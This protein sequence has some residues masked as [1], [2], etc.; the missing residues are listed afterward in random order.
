M[1]LGADISYAA[2]AVT[3]FD[4][5]PKKICGGESMR[6]RRPNTALPRVLTRVSEQRCYHTSLLFSDHG[7]LEPP[8]IRRAIAGDR[9]E[10]YEP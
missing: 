5:S 4:A 6:S 7:E 3:S 10:G 8:A 2:F 1:L 9:S